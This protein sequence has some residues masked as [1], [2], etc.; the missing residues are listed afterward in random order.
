METT[1]LEIVRTV[2]ALRDQVGEWRRD[3]QTVALV[4]TMGALHEGHLSLM[5]Q[6]HEICDR[7][8]A[9]IFVNPKQ[10]APSEDFET[11][12]RGEGEDVAKLIA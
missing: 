7:V 6:G 12:P 2:A 8:C 4:P 11:Y 10:F 9:T 3:G 5:R 1:G